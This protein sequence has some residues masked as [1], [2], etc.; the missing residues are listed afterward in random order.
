MR[1]GWMFAVG[2]A[3]LLAPALASA[4]QPQ[5]KPP[6]APTAADTVRTGREAG[7]RATTPSDSAAEAARAASATSASR[8][9]M[10]NPKMIGS[11]AWWSTHATADG[12]PKTAEG[13]PKKAETEKKP[14]KYE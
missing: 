2:G 1:I 3:C 4:Q 6:P 14:P 13:K 8:G 11:P 7:H 5:G 9:S 12:K 10:G